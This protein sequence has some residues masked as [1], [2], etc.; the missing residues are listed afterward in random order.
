MPTPIKTLD[1][2]LRVAA[3]RTDVVFD[4]HHTALRMPDAL[5]VKAPAL[6]PP[7]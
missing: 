4:S 6:V 7:T 1:I 5:A 3:F 2:V